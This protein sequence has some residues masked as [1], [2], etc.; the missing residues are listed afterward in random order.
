MVSSLLVISFAGLRKFSITKLI[1]VGLSINIFVSALI[2][3]II[4]MN[5]EKS[6]SMLYILSGNL[7]ENNLVSDRYLLLIFLVILIFSA[8][9]IPKLNFLRLDEGMFFSSIKHKNMYSILFIVGAFDIIECF[10]CGNFGIYRDYISLDFEDDCRTGFQIFIFCE[11]ILR[12]I[13]YFVCGFFI[14]NI[15]LSDADTSRACCGIYRSSCFCFLFD[16]ER[17]HS[18]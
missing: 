11:H 12:G 1:L 6:Y 18:Q 3:M 13:A 10:S 4:L 16:E 8:F 17:R 14:K 7:T 9:L 15:D 2:S 5:S